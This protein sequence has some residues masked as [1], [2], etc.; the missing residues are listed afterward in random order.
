[1][2]KFVIIRTIFYRWHLLYNIPPFLNKYVPLVP[3]PGGSWSHAYQHFD[4]L[5][6]M[7][8][9][10]VTLY[11][12]V[13]ETIKIYSA[14][15]VIRNWWIGVIETEV[16]FSKNTV[17]DYSFRIKVGLSLSAIM[18]IFHS[19]VKVVSVCIWA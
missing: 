17:R 16:C 14:P 7:I 6:L 1:M 18:K 19:I 9:L 2:Y 12:Y 3:R 8:G 4:T 13:Y 15:F 11:Y 10:Q 5:S